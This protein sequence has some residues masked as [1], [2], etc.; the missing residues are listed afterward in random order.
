DF[1]NLARELMGHKP[2]DVEPVT[3]EKLSR[4]AELVQRAKQLS[5]LT[6]FQFGRN[7]IPQSPAATAAAVATAA[8]NASPQQHLEQ[9]SVAASTVAA[10]LAARILDAADTAA[11]NA[12]RT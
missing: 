8:S 10:P 4:P 12:A 2:V 5:Q 11:A 7:A 9:P 3:N 1:V 6:N